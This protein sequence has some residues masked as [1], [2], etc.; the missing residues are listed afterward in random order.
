MWVIRVI[1]L[2]AVKQDLEAT[3]VVPCYCDK[4]TKMMHSNIL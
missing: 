4:V 3:N 2:L 1:A